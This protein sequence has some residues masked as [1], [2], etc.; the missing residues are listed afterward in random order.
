[1]K[2]MEKYFAVV[3]SIFIYLFILNLDTGKLYYC[4]PFFIRLL[5]P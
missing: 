2:A 5:G 4:I 1:M 3:L